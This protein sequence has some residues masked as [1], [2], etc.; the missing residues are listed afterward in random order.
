MGTNGN[1]YTTSALTET[2]R[3]WCR[4]RGACGTADS[5]TATVTV[6]PDVVR[7]TTEGNSFS[8]VVVVNGSPS[9]LWS[10][11]DGSTSTSTTPA[12][13]FGTATRRV[14]TLRVTPWSALQR[15]N[16]GYDAGDGGSLAIEFVPD[17]HVSAVEGLERVA[18]WLGQWCSSYN[19][20]TS[21]DFSNFVNLDTVECFLS[22]TLSQ[23][24]LANTPKLQ[25]ACFEDCNLSSLDLS[26]SPLLEDLRGAVNN[27]PTINF[28]DIGAH[29]WHICVR[30]NPQFTDRDLFADLTQ[31]PATSGTASP[32]A[33]LGDG[34]HAHYLIVSNG[35][36]L[37]RFGAASGGGQGRLV[38]MTGL[39]GCPY[40]ETLYA[41]DEGSLTA[42]GRTELTLLREFHLWGTALSP[43]AMDQIFA[44]AVATGV[45][46]GTMWCANG[47]TAASA[48]DRATLSFRGW[49]LNF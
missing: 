45:A 17:Q 13:N 16:I 22:Q 41:Y 34:E 30:D 5:R 27:Y 11:A 4:V 29:T 14:N 7:F 31:F 40:L 3:F 18:P 20:L 38:S 24:N 39:N 12:V 37:N 33:G 44:D 8:P 2:T 32:K 47:G 25:R 23:V 43:T 26:Q 46:G 21:L 15:I 28:G 35:A 19:D 9:I 48:A 42:L 1:T 6:E 10:F 49:S 36:A